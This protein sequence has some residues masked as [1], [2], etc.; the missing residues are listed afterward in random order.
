MC[1]EAD[2]LH[3]IH[4]IY[5]Q[6]NPC[7]WLHMLYDENNLTWERDSHFI[8][9]GIYSGFRVIDPSSTIPIYEVNNYKSCSTAT[10]HAKVTKTLCSELQS[11]K[12]S[13]VNVD[14]T[15]IHALGALPKS[16]GDIRIITDCSKPDKLSVN[17]YMKDVFSKFSYNRLDDVISQVQQNNYMATLDLQSAYRA[18]AIHPDNGSNFGLSWD[19]GQGKRMMCDNFLWFGT[20]V[21][22]FIFDQLTDSIS[23]HMHRMGYKCFNYLDDFIV[24]GPDYTSTREAELY[25]IHLLRK[26]RFYISWP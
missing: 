6:L 15:Q 23:L 4:G 25:L 5:A 2:P 7:A 24:I 8:L 14:K 3:H 1:Q 17:N 11:G 16:N 20:K 12:I 19:F 13:Y 21:A 9:D 26:L 18:V 22:P 10:A